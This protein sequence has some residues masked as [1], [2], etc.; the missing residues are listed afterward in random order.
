MDPVFNE[1]FDNDAKK[2]TT[3]T[4][5][6]ISS[7]WFVV[8]GVV[9]ILGWIWL[10]LLALIW[11]FAGI[12][13]FF[14][15]IV[16]MFYNSSIADKVVGLLLALFFGPLYWGFYIYKASYCTKQQTVNYYYE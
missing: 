10:I 13:A 6:N 9:G 5:T 1:R 4:K 16:C 15:S 7:D 8:G 3:E 11:F 14:A 12:A 2:E